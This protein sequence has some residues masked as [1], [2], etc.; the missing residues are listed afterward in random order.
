MLE[1]LFHPSSLLAIALLGMLAGGLGGMLGIGGSIIIIP[2]LYFI[3]GAEQQLFQAA[4]MIVNVFIALPAA[5]KH[6]GKGG[7]TYRHLRWMLPASIF[8][9]LFGVFI[10]NLFTG[11]SGN[12]ILSRLLAA[13]L[14]YVL[15]INLKR[16]IWP[17]KSKPDPDKDAKLHLSQPHRIRSIFVGTCNG[18]S[19]GLLG[20]GGG[21]ITVPLQH[22]LLKLPFKNCIAN[23]SVLIIFASAIGA[24]YKNLSL[25][26][27]G[28]SFHQSI[29][30]ALV[31]IP[32]AFV[33]S[34][35]GAHL[36]HVLPL[37]Y[38]RIAFMAIVFIAGYKL[39]GFPLPAFLAA[40]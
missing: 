5:L 36:T 1:N 22:V 4:C 14:G 38:V 20:I 33:A 24:T 34:R 23:S 31:C 39:A 8:F 26:E 37:K 27:L 16:V 7:V 9:V 12:I 40:G 6:H 29:T 2:G 28:Y 19:A 13:F 35:I 18:F 15:I 32:S 10:S 25:N 21:A 11:E 17:N 3:L 30:I